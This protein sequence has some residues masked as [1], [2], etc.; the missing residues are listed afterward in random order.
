MANELFER[1]DG[2]VAV[3]NRE[4]FEENA[5]GMIDHLGYEGFDADDIMRYLREIIKGVMN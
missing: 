5:K 3:G 2:L 1:M 4:G